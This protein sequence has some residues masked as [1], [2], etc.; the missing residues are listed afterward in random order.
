M[1][2]S[3]CCTRPRPTMSRTRTLYG[4]SRNAMAARASPI[5][6]ARSSALRA[7]PHS[8]RWCPSCHRS[9]GLLTAAAVTHAG[10]TTSSGSDESS[11]KSTA[12]WSISTGGKP[13][14]ETSSPSITR[15]SASSGSSAASISRSQPALSA[16]RLSARASARRF[17]SDS[18]CTLM[19]GT[20]LSP[21]SFAAA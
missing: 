7:S 5:T 10:S 16:I 6:R 4:G 13:V 2:N 15:S 17:A 3:A 18:P 20:S 1:A 19:M 9:P 8:K 12:I 21:S 11:S 14:M